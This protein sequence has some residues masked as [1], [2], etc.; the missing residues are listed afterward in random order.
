MLAAWLVEWR[1]I[2]GT[3]EGKV[4]RSGLVA[5]ARASWLVGLVVATWDT[6]A[7]HWTPWQGGEV[8]AAGVVLA[9]AGI[10]LRLWS[11][12]TL[13]AAFSYDVKVSDGQ[14][15]VR[16]GPYRS[17]RHPAY[18]GMLLW[19]VS[20]GLWNPSLPG[21]ALLIPATLV[22]LVVRIRAEEALLAAH[23]GARWDEHARDTARLVPGL[24]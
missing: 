11:M 3:Y 20:L 17:L 19:S 9:L 15:L 12:R 4:P 24:W 14:A 7:A 6:F 13:A 5:A 23:F 10:A 8:R 21:L 1:G 2:A 22:Q 18:T 16:H